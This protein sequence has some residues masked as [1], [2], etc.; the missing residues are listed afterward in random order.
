MVINTKKS[1]H[2]KYTRKKNHLNSSY[3]LNL[4]TLQELSEIRDLGVVIDAQ[5][6]FKAAI[7]NLFAALRKHSKI[8]YKTL[9]ISQ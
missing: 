1:Y 9:S 5:L 8:L 6:R 7:G 2:I 3:I 4:D